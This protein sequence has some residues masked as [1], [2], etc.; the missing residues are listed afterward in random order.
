[1]TSECTCG[2]IFRSSE[3]Y[4]DHLPCEGSKNFL[5]GRA[6]ERA[7][8]LKMVGQAVEGHKQLARDFPDNV[9]TRNQDA[10]KADTLTRFAEAFIGNLP[11]KFKK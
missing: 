9:S 3:D 5:A 11:G 10:I 8:I 2:K 4:R 1:M 7:E 6:Y